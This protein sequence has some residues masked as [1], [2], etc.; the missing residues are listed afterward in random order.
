MGYLVKV[1]ESLPV[2]R[3]QPASPP[4]PISNEV[5]QHYQSV[6]EFVSP[7]HR[8]L[9]ATN[10]FLNRKC[11]H[12]RCRQ[13][14]EFVIKGGKRFSEIPLVT[15]VTPVA[16]LYTAALMWKEFTREKKPLRKMRRKHERRRPVKTEEEKE[17]EEMKEKARREKERAVMKKEQ[18][19]EL[20]RE[21]MGIHA[22]ILRLIA[23]T[24]AT[25]TQTLE[26]AN[27][28]RKDAGIRIPGIARRRK[29]G[30][31]K[32]RKNTTAVSS[33]DESRSTV[34]LTNRV[35]ASLTKD[36]NATL[37]RLKNLQNVLTRLDS[38]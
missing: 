12:K 21:I 8:P 28:L 26:L 19:L 1:P 6:S 38:V 18:K 15:T 11:L 16:V 37:T 31:K 36:F 32:Q 13:L 5:V 33:S 23:Y 35:D 4:P 25:G 14:N 17:I 20:A 30:E 29:I 9:T 7:H 22:D 34:E 24:T 2:I 10:Y 27:N 3:Y